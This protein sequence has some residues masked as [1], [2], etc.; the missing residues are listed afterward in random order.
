MPDCRIVVVVM[1][2]IGH[3]MNLGSAALYAAGISAHGLAACEEMM[4]ALNQIKRR[5]SWHETL[6]G[7]PAE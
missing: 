5:R 3:S 7:T 4:V 2:G 1:P 6:S